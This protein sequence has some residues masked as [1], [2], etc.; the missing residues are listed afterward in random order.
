KTPM[1]G[2]VDEAAWV[3]VNND[4][5]LIGEVN[6]DFPTAAYLS[7]VFEGCANDFDRQAVEKAADAWMAKN[8]K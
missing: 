1:Y 8:G 7:H 2:L 4:M 6:K 5:K 3:S